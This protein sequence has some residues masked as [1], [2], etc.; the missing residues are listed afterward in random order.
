MLSRSFFILSCLTP[1]FALASNLSV[2]EPLEGA[3]VESPFQVVATSG[4]CA[5][6]AVVSM[7]YSLDDSTQTTVFPGA[8]LNALVSASVGAHT[9]NVK[10]WSKS[11]GCV[12]PIEITV[13]AANT[14]GISIKT[15]ANGAVVV[16]PFNVQANAATC[17]GQTVTAMAYSLD[18]NPTIVVKAQSINAELSSSSGSHILRVKAWGNKGAYCEED[19][20]I[21]VTFLPPPTPTPQPTPTPPSAGPSIPANATVASNIQDL[22]NW[23]W[24][25]DK[26]TSGSSNG[27]TSLVSSPSAGGGK[28]R[29]FSMNFSSG[30]GEIY[31]VSYGKDTA[32]THFVYDNYVWLNSTTDIGNVEMDMNQVVADGDTIIYGVQCDTYSKTWDYTKNAGTR[33][34]PIDKWIHSNIPCDARTWSTSKFHHIQIQYSR[35]T[36]G[37]VTYESIWFDGV[38]SDFENAFVPSAFS[39]GWGETLLT[40][41]QIDGY[42]SSGSNS[43]YF[44]NLTI[45]RW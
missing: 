1:C 13:A 27:T 34:K 23:S 32:A 24:N 35:D 22:S 33:A 17:S 43:G 18:S 28:T 15:P 25:H 2:S 8:K 4:G 30:G 5:G 39:L 19:H 9:L 41:F 7:G 40:N 44:S 42:G 45:Y 31:H 10:S 26:G 6:N 29:A 16:S 3:Q 36:N 20:T 21:D 12:E 14:S 37:W 11:G 38:K